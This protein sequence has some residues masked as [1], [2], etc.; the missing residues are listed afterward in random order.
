ME[1]VSLK[2]I[3]AVVTVARQGSLSSAAAQLGVAQSAV[4]RHVQEAE[5]ILGGALFL[6]HGRG[7]SLT[8]RGHVVVIRMNK[9]IDSVQDL[10][11]VANDSARTPSGLVTLGLVPG[12]SGPCAVRLYDV[13]QA[14]Y[15]E[16][17]LQIYEGYSGAMEQAVTDGVVD[18]A[19]TNRYRSLGKNHYATLLEVPMCLV[20]R[21]DV[22]LR[23]LAEQ[24][25][26]KA[27]PL[28]LSPAAMGKLPMVLPTAPNALL[29]II[30][31]LETQMG[32][33][34]N[35]VLS[36]TSPWVL[37]HMLIEH[38]CAALLPAHSMIK[39]IRA[40]RLQAIRVR[41]RSMTQHVALEISPKRTFSEA[42]RVVANL[43]RELPDWLLQE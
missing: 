5:R 25:S 20:A 42:S 4:S 28:S 31:D 6:R 21:P 35:D 38:D 33:K 23:H 2:C 1:A 41:G 13:I 40:G 32:F 10:Y 7:V 27:L 37:Q 12:V 17:K 15:P 9:V 11:V 19:V 18:L 14:Q 34:V 39:D 24:M 22:M 8:H 16:I 26:G 3:E 36:S 29:N 30:H 43:L